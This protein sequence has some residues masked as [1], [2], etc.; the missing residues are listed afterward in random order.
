MIDVHCHIDLY[1]NPND[2]LEICENQ[3]LF[4]FSMTNLPSHFE[5]GLPFFNLKNT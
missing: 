4:V 2:I 3:K 5:M 1:E